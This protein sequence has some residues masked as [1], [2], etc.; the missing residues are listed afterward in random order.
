LVQAALERESVRMVAAIEE[1]LQQSAGE[2][3]E[4]RIR[5]VLSCVISIK[6]HRP[7]V[8]L[9]LVQHAALLP[10]KRRVADL[11]LPVLRQHLPGTPPFAVYAVEGVLARVISEPGAIEDP[12]LVDA[13]VAVAASAWAGPWPAPARSP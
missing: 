2:P 7:R 13:L 9:A 3:L 10:S 6:R 12:G 8:H 4:V 5:A 1:S 11:V